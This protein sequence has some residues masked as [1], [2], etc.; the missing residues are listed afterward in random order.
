MQIQVS[1]SAERIKRTT[2]EKFRAMTPAD[3]KAYVE[4]FPETTHV[5]ETSL[6][7]KKIRSKSEIEDHNK[8]TDKRAADAKK[9]KK[10]KAPVPKKKIKALFDGI[11]MT[12]KIA[13][14]Y[15]KARENI[16]NDPK[17]RKEIR[18]DNAAAIKAAGMSAAVSLAGG[19]FGAIK[20]AKAAL[21]IKS[22]LVS[23]GIFKSSVGASVAASSAAMAAMSAAPGVLLGVVVAGAWMY[24][25]AKRAKRE[26]QKAMKSES[27]N[28]TFGDMEADI[29]AGFAHIKEH[30]LQP[31]QKSMLQKHYKVKL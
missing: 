3:K 22:L 19:A 5:E 10:A 17:L 8:K 1:L 2:R 24:S 27:A 7:G 29:A 14:A 11:K 6:T 28:A 25:K 30:G 12:P 15:V 9:D 20:G 21:T 23:V 31:W 26:T 4:T 13:N 18:A 16:K